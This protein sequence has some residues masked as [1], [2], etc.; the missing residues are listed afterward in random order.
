[1]RLSGKSAI[2]FWL[3]RLP[4]GERKILEQLIGVY[5]GELS[6]EALDEATGYKRSSRDAYLQRMSA[7]QLIE[8]PGRGLVRASEN[9]F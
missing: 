6:R 5:P 7:K 2:W 4:I 3:S 9:L 1:L 8:E